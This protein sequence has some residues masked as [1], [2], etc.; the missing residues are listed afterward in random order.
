MVNPIRPDLFASRPLGQSCPKLTQIYM[1]LIPR[2]G[3]I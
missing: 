1:S 2:R 3:S